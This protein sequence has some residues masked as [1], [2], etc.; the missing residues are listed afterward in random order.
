[1]AGQQVGFL[2]GWYVGGWVGM[3]GCVDIWG[4]VGRWMG[5]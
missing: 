5:L 1:M 2:G 3:R 4:T